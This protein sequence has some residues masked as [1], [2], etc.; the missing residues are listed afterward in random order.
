MCGHAAPS[1]CLSRFTPWLQQGTLACRSSEGRNQTRGADTWSAPDPPFASTFALAACAAASEGAPDAQLAANAVA[2]ATG[3]ALVA[4]LRERSRVVALLASLTPPAWAADDAFGGLY[5]RLAERT[6]DR[7][8]TR[9]GARVYRNLWLTAQGFLLELP[10][11]AR[12]TEAPAASGADQVGPGSL[13]PKTI[14]LLS[15]HEAASD[16]EILLFLAHA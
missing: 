6:D 15:P 10:T 14:Q 2:V 12:P 11:G 13:P 1:A 7:L 4:G 5:A 8:V 16:E 9:S 3:D